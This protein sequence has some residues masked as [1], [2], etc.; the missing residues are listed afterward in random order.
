MFWGSI[1]RFLASSLQRLQRFGHFSVL[2]RPVQLPPRNFLLAYSKKYKEIKKLSTITKN[3]FSTNTTLLTKVH[4]ALYVLCTLFRSDSVPDDPL[5]ARQPALVQLTE[6]RPVV[7]V[8]NTLLWL[9]ARHVRHFERADCIKARAGWRFSSFHVQTS[10]INQYF[11]NYKFIRFMILCILSL[12]KSFW[13][14]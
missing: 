13:K 2:C 10:C 3:L 11:K 14:K 1:I 12:L 4:Y 9:A 5:R 6:H 7:K 8:A